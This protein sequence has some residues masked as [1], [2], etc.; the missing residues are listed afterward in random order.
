MPFT[1]TPC[2]IAGLYEIQPKVFGDKRGYFFESYSE[3]D[4]YSVG[5]TFK[6]VQD[7]QSSSSKG[8]LRGLHF[9][10][11]HPQGKLVRVIEGEVF[12]VAVD[13]RPGSLTRGKWYGVTLSSEKHNQFYIPG[14]FAHGFL[15]LSDTAVFTYKCTD[16]Y[17]PEDEGGIIWNDPGIGIIWPDLGMDYILSE[18]DKK[19]PL[20]SE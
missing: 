5:L 15:V 1:F 3:R 19:L 12:D 14:A 9:Q 8:V 10:K 18:K 6:F 11:E 7:N 17:Y 16:F 4:F 2:P 13:L 20:F